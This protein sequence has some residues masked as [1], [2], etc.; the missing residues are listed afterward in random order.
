MRDGRASRGVLA[1]VAVAPR[2]MP[3]PLVVRARRP[4]REHVKPWLFWSEHARGL[5]P[6]TIMSYG[7]DAEMF[8]AFCEQIGCV[9]AEDVTYQ[10][11]EAYGAAQRASLGPQGDDGRASLQRAQAALSLSDARRRG[12]CESG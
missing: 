2:T 3:A 11:I 1:L 4:L 5:A 8:V 6:N 10:I 7:Y 9:Y 12:R